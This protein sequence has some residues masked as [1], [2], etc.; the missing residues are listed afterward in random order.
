MRRVWHAQEVNNALTRLGRSESVFEPSMREYLIPNVVAEV[1]SRL[2]AERIRDEQQ[3]L[4]EAR[5][6]GEAVE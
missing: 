5:E 6:R 1:V 3:A 4:Y 2:T